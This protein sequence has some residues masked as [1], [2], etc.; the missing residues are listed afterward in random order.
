MRKSLFFVSLGVF[1]VVLCTACSAKADYDVRGTWSYT[2]FTPEGNTY[3]TGMI[4]FTGKPAKGTYLQ[5]NIYEVEYEGAY[6]VEGTKIVLTGDES[7]EGTLMSATEMW[8]FWSHDE[9]AN[10][11]W[12]ADRQEP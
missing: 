3:D 5:V 1:V 11:A 9:E 2:M 6:T 8:G 7:W 4:T 10:G 12:A